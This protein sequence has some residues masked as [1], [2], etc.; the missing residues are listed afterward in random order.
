MSNHERCD[1]IWCDPYKNDTPKTQRDLVWDMTQKIRLGSCSCELMYLFNKIQHKKLIFNQLYYGYLMHIKLCEV[2]MNPN[3]IK[4]GAN[5]LGLSQN[6]MN[7]IEYRLYEKLKHIH[8]HTI[9]VLIYDNVRYYLTIGLSITGSVAQDLLSNT[10]DKM[11]CRVRLNPLVKFLNLVVFGISKNTFVGGSNGIESIQSIGKRLDILYFFMNIIKLFLTFS[12]IFYITIHFIEKVIF[13]CE[14]LIK[15]AHRMYYKKK[16]YKCMYESN[17]QCWK[18]HWLLRLCC[19]DVLFWCHLHLLAIK[20]HK[21]LT[22]GS[23]Y[24]VVRKFSKFCRKLG[25]QCDVDYVTL[26]A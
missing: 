12:D 22:Q 3:M 23:D 25:K 14:G 26:F 24:T 9:C 6:E 5:S 7:M 8:K 19:F 20:K 15:T 1:H 18:E 13:E 21:G 11:Q 10:K 4:N 16:S 17:I 2:F